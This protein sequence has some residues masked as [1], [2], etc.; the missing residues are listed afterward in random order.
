MYNTLYVEVDVPCMDK[1]TT[2]FS[3][4]QFERTVLGLLVEAWKTSVQRS[5]FVYLKGAFYLDPT[6]GTLSHVL[7]SA[8]GL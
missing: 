3:G 6:G 1:T 5:A 8:V 2:P 4:T 7:S